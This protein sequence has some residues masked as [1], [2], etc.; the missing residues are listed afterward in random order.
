M[1]K[2]FHILILEDDEADLELLLH[3]LKKSKI[4]FRHRQAGSRKDF[5]KALAEFQPDLILSDYNL[6][7]FGGLEALKLARRAREDIPFIFIS[8]SIGVEAAV[9]ALKQGAMDYL[10]KDKMQGLPSA[11][12]RALEEARRR[13]DFARFEREQEN[14]L[15]R[16]RTA[17]LE[18]EQAS[19][20]KDEFLALASHELRTPLTAM[21]G[22]TALLRSEE[23]SPEEKLK[24]LDIIE[25][26]MKFQAQ[27]IKEILDVSSLVA[28][29]LRLDLKPGP[30]VPL[31]EGVLGA[32]RPMAESK[33]LSL[34]TRL[35]P[36]PEPV[37]IDAERFY[38][39]LWNLL[40]N[41][42]KFTQPG[43]KISLTVGRKGSYAQIMVSDNGQGIPAE[44]LPHVFDRFRQSENSLTRTHGGLGLGMSIV[45]DLVHLH[46]GTVEVSSAGVGRGSCF[47]VTLPLAQAASPLASGDE[48]PVQIQP[49]AA[50]PGRPELN[51]LSI[52]LVEDETDQR[53]MLAFILSKYGARVTAVSCPSEAME[54]I[55]RKA[56]DVIVSDLAMPGEDGYD[57][58]RKVRKLPPAQGGHIP[59]AALTAYAR[60]EDRT[61]A[62]LAGYQIHI[63]KPI[64]PEELAALVANLVGRRGPY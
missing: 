59:A 34:E 58:I 4:A 23:L 51:G 16:E 30:L 28:G 54:S 38:Q 48:K 31:I 52:L 8:G 9:E 24:A 13:R 42:M 41:S 33:G 37:P 22:W 2:E 39:I 21:L 20:A 44:F 40:S 57:F 1:D 3:A 50:L 36:L 49:P 17:R 64:H 63:P 47:T 53:E 26:N 19:W 15:K 29:R 62:I 12:K 11:I 6:P 14:I 56:P 10:V 46:N 55:S 60:P 25:R 5:E 32:L 35:G 7:S 61:K 27:I 18:A 45:R 43:G